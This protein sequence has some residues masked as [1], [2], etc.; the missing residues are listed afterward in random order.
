M[1]VDSVRGNFQGL[2]RVIDPNPIAGRPA[3]HAID[4]NVPEF[5]DQV[6]EGDVD[7]RN[8]VDHQRT[9]SDVAMCPVSL[10]P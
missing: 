7:G 2:V 9:P 3:E 6:P 10:L 1:L 5:S 8:G 4:G